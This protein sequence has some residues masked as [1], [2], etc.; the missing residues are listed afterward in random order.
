MFQGT[1]GS[2]FRKIMQMI[3]Q[4]YNENDSP[5]MVIHAGDMSYAN[6]DSQNRWDIW[7]ENLEPVS[8]RIPYM[9]AVGNHESP[10]SFISYTER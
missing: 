10:C 9:Y 4:Q 2:E 5:S 3:P 7:G 6:A 8:S 1:N